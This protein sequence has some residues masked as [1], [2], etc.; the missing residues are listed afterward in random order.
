MDGLRGLVSSGLGS[1]DKHKR[2]ECRAL[3]LGEVEG[4]AE[5]PSAELQPWLLR[6]RATPRIALPHLSYQ[7][8]LPVAHPS[9]PWSLL[10]SSCSL[11]IEPTKRQ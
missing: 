4:L 3:G 5:V 2:E 10:G 1:R 6:S 11:L 9:L 7:Q 8:A